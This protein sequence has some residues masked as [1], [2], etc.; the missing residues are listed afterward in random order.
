MHTV[1][2]S[3][4]AVVSRFACSWAVRFVDKLLSG[5]REAEY[6]LGGNWEYDHVFDRFKD[7]ILRQE[8]TMEASLE[9][10]GYDLDDETT[11]QLVTGGRQPEKVS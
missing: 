6:T 10:V 9:A 3:N 8:R 11:L 7:Y 2:P 1:L 5:I 4:R